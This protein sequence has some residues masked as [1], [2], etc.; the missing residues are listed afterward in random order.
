MTM[1][2]ALTCKE[3]VELVTEYLEGTLPDELRAGFE[4]HLMDCHGCQAY[5]EQM[6]ETIRLTGNISEADVSP[7][8]EAALVEAFRDWQAQRPNPE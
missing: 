6:R 8:A 2:Q 1:P 3:I 4:Y 5:L 7:Q